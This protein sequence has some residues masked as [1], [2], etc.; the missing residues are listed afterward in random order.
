MRP[1]ASEEPLPHDWILMNH[2]GHCLCGAVRFEAEADPVA[3][4]YCHCRMCQ[5]ISGAP[6]LPWASFP[7]DRFSYTSGTPK[8]YRSS[9]HGQREFCAECG[10]QLA[11]RSV[12]QPGKIEINVG[13]LDDT[14]KVMPQ[15]HIWCN[16]KI[17]WFE[18]K[19]ELPRFSESGPTE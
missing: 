10:S 14:S 19:D 2:S 11:F 12:D 13:A 6:N 16:S 9:A 5:R 8:V 1:V 7:T 3:V 15:Y 17:S 4:G 18:T